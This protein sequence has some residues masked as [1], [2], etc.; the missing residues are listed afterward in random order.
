VFYRHA[1]EQCPS[2][3]GA[4]FLTPEPDCDP[5]DP[6]DPDNADSFC[7]RFDGLMPDDC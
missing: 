2:C 4:G 1:I 6:A 7:D 3:D 5:A